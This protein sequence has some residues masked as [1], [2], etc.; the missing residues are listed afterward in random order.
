M[1]STGSLSSGFRR[2]RRKRKEV[3]HF[4]IY[5]PPKSLVLTGSHAGPWDSVLG[6][7][8]STTTGHLLSIV[9]A[10]ISQETMPTGKIFQIHFTQTDRI[11][12]V[13]VRPVQRYVYRVQQRT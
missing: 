10:L 1:I 9:W 8:A 13:V 11:S 4:P 5:S 3:A 12:G 2:I 6:S 7:K